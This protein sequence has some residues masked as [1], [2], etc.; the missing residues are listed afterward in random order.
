MNIQEAT[1][2]V[3]TSA[4]RASLESMVRSATMEHRLVE[5]ARIVLLAA[6]GRSTR[7]IAAELGTWPGRVSRWRIRF[8]LDRLAGL[9]DLPRPGPKPRYTTETGQRILRLLDQPPPAGHGRWTGPLL[10]QVL[11][12]VSDQH[13]WCWRLTRSRTSRRWSGRKAT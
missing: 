2:V 3:L 9:V 4:E 12:D 7:S 6:A 13:I 5:R 10:A 11:G 1:V 8:A